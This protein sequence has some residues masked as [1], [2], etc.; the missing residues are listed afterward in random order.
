MELLLWSVLVVLML[1]MVM[2]MLLLMLRLFLRLLASGPL[3][4]HLRLGLLLGPCV[5]LRRLCCLDLSLYTRIKIVVLL[6]RLSWV[7]R[8]YSSQRRRQLVIRLL[9]WWWLLLLMWRTFKM[10]TRRRRI[11]LYLGLP[12]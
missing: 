10:M 2:V 3:V 5:R 11:G 9:L 8:V 4:D 6:M 1:V 7:G 12:L